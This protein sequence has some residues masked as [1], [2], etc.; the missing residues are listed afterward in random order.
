VVGVALYVLVRAV[1]WLGGLVAVVVVLF[2]LGALWQWGWSS[3]QRTHPTP[4]P[5]SGLQPA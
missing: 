2:G 3:Y 4:A 5:V 1:P